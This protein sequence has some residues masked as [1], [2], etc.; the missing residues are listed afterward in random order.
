MQELRALWSSI[1]CPQESLSPFITEEV[2]SVRF[3]AGQLKDFF[4]IAT[5]PEGYQVPKMALNALSG[6]TN[7]LLQL[8]EMSNREPQQASIPSLYVN[9]VN[10]AGNTPKNDL[11][12]IL[13][14]SMTESKSSNRRSLPIGVQD[15]GLPISDRATANLTP[16]QA[17]LASDY[18]LNNMSNEAPFVSDFDLMTMP[19]AVMDL[20][21]AFSDLAGG[22]GQY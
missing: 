11:E 13:T 21:W 2:L 18:G 19:D 5:G 22:H 3:Y 14:T 10:E 8:E 15:S 7:R 20:S 16:F 17:S 6:I 12:V 1:H 4:E 9:I